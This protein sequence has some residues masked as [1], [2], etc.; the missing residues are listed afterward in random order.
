[1]MDKWTFGQEDDKWMMDGEC[2]CPP[3]IR[4]LKPNPQCD[5]V[6]RWGLQEVIWS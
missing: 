3:K 2:L 1:M 5:G 4:M 6:R